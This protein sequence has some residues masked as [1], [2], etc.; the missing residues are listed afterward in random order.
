[1]AFLV[2]VLFS[3]NECL[4]NADI[5]ILT[6]FL[7]TFLQFFLNI[8]KSCQILSTSLS[9]KSIASF[10]LKLQREAESALPRPYQSA[11]ATPV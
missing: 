7:V 5:S 11:K 4:R 2:R 6:S 8:E 9:F 3:L 10:K 1:M